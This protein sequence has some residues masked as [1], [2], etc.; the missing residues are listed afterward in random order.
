LIDA[1]RETFRQRFPEQAPFIPAARDQSRRQV[2]PAIDRILIGAD[3]SVWLRRY[4]VTDTGLGTD[5]DPSP[6]TWLV[7]P[8]EGD[9]RYVAAVG[10]GL[11]LVAAS[12]A[13]VLVSM[14][15]EGGD[16]VVRV[17]LPRTRQ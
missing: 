16:K 7:I 15:D 2:L 10:R 6:E 8:P 13:Y 14:A 9:A 17:A 3:S 12:S 11:S 5:V 4:R 1:S